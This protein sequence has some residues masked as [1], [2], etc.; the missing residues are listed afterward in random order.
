MNFI[1]VNYT[2]DYK[3]SSNLGNYYR[4]NQK[5]YEIIIKRLKKLYPECKIHVITDKK[6]LHNVESYIFPNLPRNNFAKLYI[7]GLLNEPAIYIDNDILLIKKFLPDDLK[8]ENAFNLFAEYRNADYKSLSKFIKLKYK[9]YNTGVVFVNKPDKNITKEMLH[10]SKDFLIHKNGWV[11]D[12][13]V[14]S[15]YVHKYNLNMNLSNKINKYRSDI[16]FNEL[17]SYQS[18]HYT[19]ESKELFFKEYIPVKLL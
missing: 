9:H 2:N 18:V 15:Y 13:Y 12:E 17:L 16:K 10:L 7:F 3:L 14:I 19:G 5:R 1:L 11:N 4:D 6:N 8:T